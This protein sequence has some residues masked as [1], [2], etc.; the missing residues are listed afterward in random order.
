MV[1]LA[2]CPKEET[3]IKYVSELYNITNEQ[4]KLIT[5]CIYSISIN[6]TLLVYTLLFLDETA[7]TLQLSRQTHCL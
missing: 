2:V 5:N 6:N 7:L 3:Y 4:I 1:L